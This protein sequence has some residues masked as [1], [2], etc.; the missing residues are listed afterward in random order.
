[1]LMFKFFAEKQS[2]ATPNLPV[3]EQE[4]QQ[5]VLQRIHGWLDMLEQRIA[6]LALVH[7]VEALKAGECEQ[8]I[9]RHITLMVRLFQVR[10]QYAKGAREEDAQHILGAPL[11]PDE[12]DPA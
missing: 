4:C 5:D 10:Q 6:A 1:M 2:S 3:S 9:D 7:N 11:Q 12:E 8:A